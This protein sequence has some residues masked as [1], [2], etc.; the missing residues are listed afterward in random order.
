MAAVDEVK[1]LLRV[2]GV[3]EDALIGA[4]VSAA[5]EAAEA[6]LGR[7]ILERA[8]IETVAANGAWQ[9]L[10]ASPVMAITGV[11]GVAGDGTAVALPVGAY[12]IDIDAGGD[13]WVRSCGAGVGRLRVSASAGLAA[14]WAA[15]PAGIAHGIVRLAA[16]LF[17]HRDDGAA[18]PPAVAALWRPWRRPR[19]DTRRAP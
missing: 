14:D 7:V 5:T 9:R 11:E 15:V 3:L 13:G 8:V 16:H 2:D 4:L 19:I 1:A 17:A 6:F 12:A 18:L 10:R